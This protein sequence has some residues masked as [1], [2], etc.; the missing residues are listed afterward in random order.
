[1]HQ[2]WIFCVASTVCDADHCQ[3]R[4]CMLESLE[5]NPKRVVHEKE[6]PECDG[7]SLDWGSRHPRCNERGY[8]PTAP[9]ISSWRFS[10]HAA[11]D[12]G[13]TALRQNG[14]TAAPE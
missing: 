13:V 14:R 8:C 6:N 3:A 10:Y 12:V 2:S 7:R 5:L 1:M 4:P 9:A 11:P